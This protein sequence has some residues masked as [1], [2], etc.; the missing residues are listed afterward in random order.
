MG[1]N[2][3]TL[4]FSC[5]GEYAE[6]LD[7][8]GGNL[9]KTAEKALQESHKLVTEQLHQDMKRHRQ[10]G[11]TEKSIKDDST[12]TWEGTTAVID[13]GFKISEGG[14]PSIF[15]MYGTPRMAKDQKIY[16]DVYGGRTKKKIQEIQRKIFDEAIEKKMGG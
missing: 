7:K 1:K 12:V 3:L 13:V 16:N 15:L 6:I 10:T 9:E 5:L 2:K 11:V 8:I 14:L 4:D